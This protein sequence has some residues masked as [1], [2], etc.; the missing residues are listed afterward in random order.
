MACTVKELVEFFKTLSEDAVVAVDDGGLILVELDE[1]N[2]QT[3]NYYEIGGI[4]LDDEDWK[5]RA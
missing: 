2:K 3:G 5:R 4:P 1:D